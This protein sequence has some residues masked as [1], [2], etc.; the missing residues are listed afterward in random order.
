MNIENVFDRIAFRYD[1]FNRISSLGIDKIWR[2]KL[3]SFIEKEKKLK[4]LDVAIGTGDILLS[5]FGNGCDIAYAAG[6]DISSEMLSIA[7]KNLSMHQVECKQA[8]AEQIPYPENHFDAVTCAF[9]VRNFSDLQSGLK[10]MYRILKPGG[11]LLI[12]EF[13]LPPNPFIRF[14]YLLYLKLYIPLL[15]AILTGN[16]VAYRYLSRTIQSFPYG[17]N[18]CDMLH[19]AGFKNAK[20]E[21]MTA[22]IVTFYSASKTG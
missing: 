15:G 22:G 17:K 5:L 8:K 11:K 4:I 20:A 16:Y 19:S 6:I 9:G 12:L 10:E 21:S 3:T 2:R 13:S 1:L 14:F 7:K 18:F